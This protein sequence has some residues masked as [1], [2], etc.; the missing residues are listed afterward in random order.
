[1][2]PEKSSTCANKSLGKIC[3]IFHNPLEL[4]PHEKK[5]DQ[6]VAFF[7]G[8]QPLAHKSVNQ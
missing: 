1:V 4:Y 3:A 7:H 5:N 2:K 8:L 6:K